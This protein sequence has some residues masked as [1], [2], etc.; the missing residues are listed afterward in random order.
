MEQINPITALKEI[1]VSQ[2]VT[3]QEQLRRELKSVG[4][5]WNQSTVS[6]A[7]KKIGVIRRFEEG[8]KVYCLPSPEE[9]PP[10]A[11]SSIDNLVVDI[12]S[13]GQ[14]IVINTKPGSAP[15]VAR[16][17]DH[18]C[19]D[20]ILGTIAG[21]DSIFVAPRSVDDIERTLIKLRKNFSQ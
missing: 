19:R 18:Y 12:S 14:M 10:A 6:R 11:Y 3:T 20:T 15:L 1:L 8:N 16:H 17:L 13:N 9:S 4:V 21:D 7:L 2:Q 5:N